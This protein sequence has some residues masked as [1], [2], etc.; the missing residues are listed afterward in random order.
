M[1]YASVGF[2]IATACL[3]GCSS[4]APTSRS[5]VGY[6]CASSG[7]KSAA[8]SSA[9]G[10]SNQNGAQPLSTGQNKDS[11]TETKSANSEQAPVTQTGQQTQQGGNILTQVGAQVG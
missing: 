10:D 2:L 8:C 9:Q 6:G 11:K 5:G 4:D 7:T 3:T 1:K